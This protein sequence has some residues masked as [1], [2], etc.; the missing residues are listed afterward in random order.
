MPPD[1]GQALDDEIAAA[2]RALAELPLEPLTLVAA[3]RSWILEA[4]RDQDRL[5]TAAEGLAIFP[6]G[7]LLWESAIVLAD[8]LGERGSLSGQ[9]VLEL[10]AGTG[11]AG[12]AAAGLGARVVQ[13]DYS[14]EALALCRRNAAANGATGLTHR[15]DDWTDWRDT[16]RYD[17]VIGADILYE[18]ALHDDIARVLDTTLKPGELAILTDPGRTHTAPFIRS[19]QSAGWEITRT[20]RRVAALPPAQSGETVRVDVIVARKGDRLKPSAAGRRG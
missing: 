3:G 4:V 7:L 12:L 10:G 1:T 8:V 16:T 13:T 11:L 6:F 5:L 19:L 2:D 18:P 17:L 15:L 9:S 20:E 14:A